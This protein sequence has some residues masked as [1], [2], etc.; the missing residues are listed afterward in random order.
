MTS[1]DPSI[2]CILLAAGSARRFGGGK[3]TAP[4][5]GKPLWHWAAGA[6]ERAG[7]ADR[8]LVVDGT[9]RDAPDRSGWFRVENSLAAKGMASSIRAGVR[10]ASGHARIVI[11]LGDMPFVAPGH[12][13]DLARAPGVVFTRYPDGRPGC[14]AGFPASIFPRLLALQGEKGAA[15]L[16][17]AD[18]DV[19]LLSP[20]HDATWLDIDRPDDL[21]RAEAILARGQSPPNLPA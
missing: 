12:L 21:A 2:A 16:F 8:Y 18:G 6:I 7:F 10:A 11:A 9:R 19:R 17:D 3:L 1:P 5:A 20:A 15:S 4:L 14:P 13:A